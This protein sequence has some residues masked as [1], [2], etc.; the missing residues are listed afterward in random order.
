MS[1]RNLLELRSLLPT[2]E[3]TLVCGSW[4]ADFARSLGI[5]ERI[6]LCDYYK[7][8]EKNGGQPDDVKII[9]AQKLGATFALEDFD[10]AV[11]FRVP[12]DSRKL[13]ELINARIRAGIGTTAEFPFLDIGLPSMEAFFQDARHVRETAELAWSSL[14]LPLSRA[15]LRSGRGGC[16]QSFEQRLFSHR[17][18]RQLGR[19]AIPGQPEPQAVRPT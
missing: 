7:A 5:F 8:D 11:D 19:R 2:A 18:R 1:V 16:L 4:N 3:L 15:A 14:R 13:L 9:E 10:L 6:L 12:S 17:S